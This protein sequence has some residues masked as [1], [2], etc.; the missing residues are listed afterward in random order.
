M[1]LLII[2][3]LAFLLIVLCIVYLLKKK[4][5]KRN[6]I[7]IYKWMKMGAQKR[8]KLDQQEKIK[9]MKNKNSLISKIRKEYYN[10][11]KSLGRD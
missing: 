11:K 9:V 5:N 7:N 6:S 8:R 10:H 2:L 3:L 4:I 1:H